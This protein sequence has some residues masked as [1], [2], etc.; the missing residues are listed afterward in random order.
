MR[1]WV[2]WTRGIKEDTCWDEYWVLYVAE[3]SLDST[4][5]ITITHMLTNLD[6]NLKK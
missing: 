3:E 2:T 4:L 1:G 6:V 5:E